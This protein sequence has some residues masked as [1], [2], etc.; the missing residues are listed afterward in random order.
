MKHSTWTRVEILVGAPGL[1]PSLLNLVSEKWAVPLRAGKFEITDIAAKIERVTDGDRGGNEDNSMGLTGQENQWVREKEKW[2]AETPK[3]SQ[4]KVAA[5]SLPPSLVRKGQALLLL[6]GLLVFPH[7]AVAWW[8]DRSAPGF[9]GHPSSSRSLKPRTRYL[10]LKIERKI[11]RNH[12]LVL[13]PPRNL[14]VHPNIS[15][16]GR[17]RPE[18]YAVKIFNLKVHTIQICT[19]KCDKSNST[20]YS[21]SRTVD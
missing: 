13:R 14:L 10:G 5:P 15:T 11:F 18:L 2:E 21:Y 20:S 8:N 6:G 16:L 17:T 19:S 9:R 12:L 7:S 3:Q 1:V 4:G